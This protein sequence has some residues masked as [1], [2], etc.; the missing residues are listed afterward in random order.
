MLNFK[1]KKKFEDPIIVLSLAIFLINYSYTSSITSITILS[2]NYLFEFNYYKDFD[3]F[4][5][6]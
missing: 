6:N 3:S 5:Y 1:I 4:I 2:F